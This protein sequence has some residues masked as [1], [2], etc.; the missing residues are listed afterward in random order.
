MSIEKKI[1]KMVI[2]DGERHPDTL[3]LNFDASIIVI[4]PIIEENN[5]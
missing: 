3:E 2:N 4:V 5:E 1:T